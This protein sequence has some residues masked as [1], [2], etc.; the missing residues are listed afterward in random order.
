MRQI[1][2]KTAR[3]C[4]QIVTFVLAFAMIITS[5]AVSGTDAQA[6]KKK[7]KKIKIGVKVGSSGI[8]V[9]K[10]GQSKKLKVSVTPKKASKKVSYKSSN[11][12]VVKVSSKGVVKALKKK[13]SAKITV[14][15]K[16]NKKKKATI[17]VKIGTPIKKVSIQKTAVMNWRSA[18]WTLVEVN[19]QK[20]KKYEEFK[21]KVT[22][23]NGKFQV[24][25]GRTV[26][27]KASLSPKKPTSKKI[28][29]SA[30]KSGTYVTLVQLGR[31]CK[32][33]LK[34]VKK[35]PNYDVKITAQAA[36]GSGKKATVT[37]QVGEF[38]TDKTPAPTKAPDTRIKTVVEDFESYAVGTAWNRYTAA[39]K[40]SS[41]TMTVVADPENPENKCLQ[42]KYTGPDAYDYAP[43]FGV[44]ISK[45]KDSTGKSA[46]GKTLGS[47]TGIKMDSRVV[48]TSG[49]V[50]YKNIYVYF[51]QYDSIKATDKFAASGNKTASASVDASGNVVA[52]DAP[53]R[54]RSL[55][56]GVEISMAEGSKDEG[57]I[58]L[59]NGN[60]SKESNKYFPMYYSTWQPED[61]S[62]HFAANSCTAG[63][64]PEEDANIKVGFAERTLAFVKDRIKE[65]DSTLLEQK[66]VDVVV[67]STYGGSTKNTGGTDLTLYLD[68]I[69]FVEEE[70]PV[71]G[72]AFDAENSVTRVA[73]GGSAQLVV[74]YT[75]DNTTQKGLNWTTT[76]NKVTVDASGKVTV[77]EDF[78]FGGATE[79]VVTVTATST[80]NPAITKSIDIT[81]YAVEKANEPLVLNLSDMYDKETTFTKAD[82][83]VTSIQ[84]DVAVNVVTDA[85]GKEAWHLAFTGNNQ[86]AFF[87]FPEALDLSAYESVEITGFVPGQT[88]FDFW[89][90]DFDKTV[91]SWWESSFK[92]A[93]TYPFFNGSRPMR[94][95]DA[96]IPFE[97][98]MLTDP[99]YVGDPIDDF[100]VG[101]FSDY[102]K[103]GTIDKG[104][105]IGP[106]GVET[107][108]I[109]LKDMNP[110]DLS[111]VQWFSIGTQGLPYFDP[112][113]DGYESAAPYWI[114]S[115]RLMPK[116][117]DDVETPSVETP[118][119]ETTEVTE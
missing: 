57:G 67:G 119:G 5:L 53:N 38:Q 113:G 85:D 24:A 28:K 55:R 7:V 32:V 60:A 97:E 44:D 100:L 95:Q 40:S 71:T 103:T 83:T 1:G 61:A 48:G 31:T 39:G 36:D 112:E 107:L 88:S 117:T 105:A 47:Y 106:N 13:G 65:A 22:M 79:K 108:T 104:S 96:P 26:T 15:S 12:K 2:T 9:L 99:K 59:Y 93:D 8:L 111:K 115:V 78:D 46:E 37:L 64:K 76:D 20:Q 68:N 86:R 54:D 116:T 63:F 45:L 21:E 33:A 62:T 29:W 10:K 114:Y 17:T 23:K 98:S 11:K 91:D 84:E 94:P 3:K 66:K 43:V 69:A 70:V 18:N 92:A 73:A 52:A 35:K 30:N 75:P 50:T 89:T 87:K 72:I 80:V 102:Q 25:A 77:A 16:Q 51:D 49:D 19:G 27:L 41:G 90:A 82:G 118:S 34:A 101:E 74:A 42:I 6:A 56:F 58:T 14:T 81:V 109:K 4:R 110:G